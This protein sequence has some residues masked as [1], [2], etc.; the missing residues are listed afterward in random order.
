MD[1]HPVVW[2]TPERLNTILTYQIVNTANNNAI[3]KDEQVKVVLTSADAEVIELTA[4]YA[5][6]LY[7]FTNGTAA[8]LISSPMT[9]S[10]VSNYV[11]VAA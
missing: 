2:P 6:G 7:T 11:Q 5:D 3:L 1:I 10:V 4:T 8:A 9:L